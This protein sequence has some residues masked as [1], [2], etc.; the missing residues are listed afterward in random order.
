MLS[1]RGFTLVELLVVIAIIGILIALLLPAVQAAREAARRVQ[2]A[3]NLKQIG[4]AIL[5]Y[6]DANNALP[7]SISYLAEGPT[8]ADVPTGKGW[9]ISALPQLEQQAAFD[10]F[11][12]SGSFNSGGGLRNPANQELIERHLPVLKCP[13]DPTA[14]E[15]ITEQWQWKGIPMATTSYKGVM[16]DSMMG[17]A[18]AFPGATAY[19]NNGVYECNGL[20]WRTSIQWAKRDR[21]LP[22]GWSNTM[23]VGEDSAEY[24]WHAAWVFSNGDTSST[25]APLNFLPDP[26]DPATWWEMRGFRSLH[27]GGAYF[28]FGDGAVHFLSEGI[29]I[30]TYRGLSTRNVGET[31]VLP[32]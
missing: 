19:C 27:P 30:A 23:M 8:P 4:L 3:N 17:Q 22:D 7:P 13:T 16:G 11:D 15:L 2:C 21:D 26:P 31:V 9:I 29:E 10:A 25:Y 28:A 12:L 6:R 20:F 5:T 14:Y 18:T 32:N 1:R 24:N